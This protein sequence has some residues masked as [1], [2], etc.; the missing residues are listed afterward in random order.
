ML[1]FLSLC[2]ATSHRVTSAWLFP[3]LWK[4][5]IWRLFV[6]QSTNRSWILTKNSK[7]IFHNRILKFVHKNHMVPTKHYLNYSWILLFKIRW[8]F[9][10]QI[11]NHE[12]PLIVNENT[13]PLESN[14]LFYS[15]FNKKLLPSVWLFLFYR[16]TSSFESFQFIHKTIFP[17]GRQLNIICGQG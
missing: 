15:A 4:R 13:D 12:H 16:E 9:M 7:K 2:Q 17:I 11:I 1:E 14:C 3:L 5:Q 10:S 8:L 6:I